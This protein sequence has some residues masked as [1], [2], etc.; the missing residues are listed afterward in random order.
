MLMVNQNNPNT[1]H[2]KNV[3]EAFQEKTNYDI[4]SF[5]ISKKNPIKKRLKQSLFLK[6]PNQTNCCYKILDDKL[7]A[8]IA[9]VALSAII[10]HTY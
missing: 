5:P 4:I 9:N 2:L 10:Y 3:L 7:D 6:V 1:F 8:D